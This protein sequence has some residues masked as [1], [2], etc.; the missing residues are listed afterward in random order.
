M[1]LTQL[2][3]K[4]GVYPFLIIVNKVNERIKTN[5]VSLRL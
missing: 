4:A 1:S 5:N 2:K 3:D